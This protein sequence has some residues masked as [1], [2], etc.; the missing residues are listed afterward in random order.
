MNILKSEQFLRGTD[1]EMTHQH[2]W[3]SLT[4]QGKIHQD[5][6]NRRFWSRQGKASGNLRVLWRGVWGKP[7]KWGA[8]STGAGEIIMPNSWRR[9]TKEKMNSICLP[10]RIL[11]ARCDS[12]LNKHWM[13]NLKWRGK[14]TITY[15]TGN[16]NQSTAWG[17]TLAPKGI[18][19]AVWRRRTQPKPSQTNQRRAVNAMPTLWEPSKYCSWKI[20][21]PSFRVACMM[22]KS[23]FQLN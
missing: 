20:Y 12:C 10:P 16:A 3:E 6:S 11:K 19:S 9:K 13:S 5:V 7:L 1:A 23:C 22:G 2:H 8:T 21:Q 14:S 15:R 4:I 17:V 18:L